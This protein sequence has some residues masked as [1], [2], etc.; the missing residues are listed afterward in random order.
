MLAD[1]NNL[2]NWGVDNFNASKGSAWARDYVITANLKS[3]VDD[4]KY[5]DV[6]FGYVKF[7]YHVEPTENLIMLKL[8]QL[9][10]PLMKSLPTYSCWFASTYMVRMILQ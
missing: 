1:C 5:S 10:L 3:G 9:R 8:T 2:G 4:K 6:E 7:V